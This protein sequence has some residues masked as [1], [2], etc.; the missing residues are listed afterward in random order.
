MV[1][2]DFLERDEITVMNDRISQLKYS[3]EKV[4][5]GQFAKIGDLQKKYDD[6]AARME[7][8]E[9]NICI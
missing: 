7:I 2:L 5:K 1:Q 6:L 4:R 9:R 3:C 8:I